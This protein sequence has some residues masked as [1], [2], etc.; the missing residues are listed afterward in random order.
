MSLNWHIGELPAVCYKMS[1]SRMKNWIAQYTGAVEGG[2]TPKSLVSVIVER[3]RV[4]PAPGA[5]YLGLEGA[6]DNN[7]TYLVVGDSYVAIT[8][9]GFIE[10][11]CFSLRMGPD[12]DPVQFIGRVVEPLVRLS[13][14]NAGVLPLH[15][16]SAAL[17]DRGVLL[18]AWCHTGK[19]NLMLGL[20]ARGA[21]IMADDWSF[22]DGE[23][24]IL[25]NPKP[26]AV[27]DYNLRAFPELSSRLPHTSK[28]GVKLMDFTRSTRKTI[29]LRLGRTPARIAD[30]A[31]RALNHLLVSTV[32]LHDLAPVAR[33]AR[34]HRIVLLSSIDRREVVIRQVG[35]EEFVNATN[36]IFT[37]ENWLL[38][39]LSATL[40]MLGMAGIPDTSEIISMY[41][42]LT[43][44][45]ACGFEQGEIFEL[46]VPKVSDPGWA[47]LAAE[48]V[49]SLIRD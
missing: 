1:D 4:A 48:R 49:V 30:F 28:L 10:R 44:R 43:E 7:S 41:R 45:V 9:P 6:V 13:L 35:R 17:D 26:A 2:D 5:R 25:L 31:L 47:R 32:P 34:C 39:C 14:L 3:K 8:F 11:P 23:R 12:V 15:A 42:E 38:F 46:S 19:T 27:F 36:E 29:S 18:P 24:Q 20:A 33:L 21:G 37:Y 22:I 16:S 40:R